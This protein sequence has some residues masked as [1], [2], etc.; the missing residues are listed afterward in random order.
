LNITNS[1][2]DAGLTTYKYLGRSVWALVNN[3]GNEETTK[4]CTT[5]AKIQLFDKNSGEHWPLNSA[6]LA[7]KIYL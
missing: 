7:V 2:F 3:F 6:D 1:E 5:E 4:G